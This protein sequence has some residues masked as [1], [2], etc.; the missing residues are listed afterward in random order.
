MPPTSPPSWTTTSNSEAGPH[1]TTEAADVAASAPARSWRPRPTANHLVRTP[2]GVYHMRLVIP[3]HVRTLHPELPGELRRS[4]KTSDRCQALRSAREMCRELVTSLEQKGDAML[5][6]NAAVQGPPKQ[7]FRIEWADGALITELYPGAQ[8]DTIR[9]FTRIVEQLAMP[10]DATAPQMPLPA[11]PMSHNG[12]SAPQMRGDAGEQSQA[13]DA[14]MDAEAPTT[15]GELTDKP[16]WLTEAIPRWRTE[17]GTTFSENTWNFAYASSFRQFVE[18]LGDTRRDVVNEDGSVTESVLDIRLADLTRRHFVELHKQMQ[19]MPQR[20]GKRNDGIEA[21]EVIRRAVAERLKPQSACNVA[22]KLRHALPLVIF[23]KKKGWISEALLDEFSIQLKD[24]DARKAKAKKRKKKGKSG[25]V[26]LSQEEYKKTFE[27]EAYLEG[28]IDCDWKYWIDPIRVYTAARVSE[29]AQLLTS[30]IITLCGVPCISFTDVSPDDEDEGQDELG[31][32][33]TSAALGNAGDEEEYLRRLKNI[34][35]RRIIPIAP[36]LIAMGFLDYVQHRKEM[37]GTEPGP[38]FFGL[39]WAPKSGY[40]RKPSEHTLQLLKAAKV[41][42]KRRKVGHSLR[43]TC[44][45]HLGRLGLRLEEI[46][47]YI[48]HSTG[49]ELEESYNEGH[50]GPA[51][52]VQR[53]VKLLEQLDFGVR[54]PTWAEVLKLRVER[55]REQQ[56]SRKN[57]YAR[58]LHAS[59]HDVDS[60]SN[61]D[62]STNEEA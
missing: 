51:Y 41:W 40:G 32:A 59:A 24:A 4:T 21:R 11:A 39:T 49:T 53:V 44:A 35:S 8:L 23:L 5:G 45:Q 12:Q 56:L 60:V 14:P 25:A 16:Q 46:Q 31:E 42:Q 36:Q 29:V 34:A 58:R 20:Q 2:A 6:S 38:L 13:K 52:P 37:L 62:Q 47:R 22:K 57:G 1:L 61:P 33:E 26:A 43:A 17:G 55:A 54:F 28:A 9:L 48:G 18:L 7:G 19:L 3:A 27:S 10:A 30:D 50:E 15:G